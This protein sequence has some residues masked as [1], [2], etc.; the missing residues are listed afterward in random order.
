MAKLQ[1]KP[2]TLLNPV[3]VVLVS[4]GDI[5]GIKNIITIAWVGTV[6]SDP[7]MVSISI[8]PERYSYGLIKTSGE[9]VINLPN[10]RLVRAVDLCGVIS[11]KE[12]DKF[13]ETGLTPTPAQHLKAPLIDEAPLSLECKVTSIIPLGSHD[14]F[15]AEVLGVQVAENLVDQKGRLN[16]AQA[17]LISYVHGHYW[18]LK[19]A[20]GSFGFS[21]KK[22]GKRESKRR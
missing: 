8:R 21:V 22:Q 19:E 15:L 6:A 5:N 14:L 3:P 4:C 12:H 20:I 13:K 16:L 1:W 18:T 7:V 17:E 2:G 9:F 11:G 10:R